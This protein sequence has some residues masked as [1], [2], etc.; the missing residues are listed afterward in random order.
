MTSGSTRPAAASAA[1]LLKPP[2]MSNAAARLRPSIQNTPKRESSGMS[3]PGR[4]L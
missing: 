2:S 4:M 1:R 3:S